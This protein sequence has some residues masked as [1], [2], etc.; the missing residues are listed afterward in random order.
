MAVNRISLGMDRFA[1]FPVLKKWRVGDVLL[2]PIVF[3]LN[4]YVNQFSPPFERQFYVNDLTINHPFAEKERVPNAWNIVYSLFIPIGVISLLTLLLGHPKHRLY[5][6]YISLLGLL[7]SVFVN[8][9]FTDVLKNWIGRHR[10]DF[11]ARC[12]PKPGV[13]LNTLVFAKDVCTTKDLSK[14][15]DGFRTTPSGH[16]STAFSGLG[17]LSLWLA[18]QLLADHPL[19]GSWRK[20]VTMIPVIGAALVALSRTEDYRHHFIDVILGS[21]LGAIVAHWSYRRN[22]PSLSSN[23]AF[24]PILDDSDVT[25]DEVLI[26][27]ADQG[28][29]EGLP[30]RSQSDS[31]A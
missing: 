10:P 11:I 22:F 5:L 29:D 16:S 3:I 24:K 9:L 6:G 18:G 26:T 17:Y 1:I 31:L 20:L 25:A 27:K 15:A 7:V 23:I 19:S 4:S 28:L 8:E 2:V 12:V 13:P 21:L 14:L 30:L